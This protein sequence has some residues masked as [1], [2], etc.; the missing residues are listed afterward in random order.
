MDF[1]RPRF[2]NILLIKPIYHRWYKWDTG[3]FSACVYGRIP[4]ANIAIMH[5]Y[6]CLHFAAFQKICAKTANCQVCIITFEVKRYGFLLSNIQHTQRQGLKWTANSHRWGLLHCLSSGL[7]LFGFVSRA[8]ALFMC[9][10]LCANKTLHIQ[11][12]SPLPITFPGSLY[13]LEQATMFPHNCPTYDY[14]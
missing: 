11:L 3:Q 4:T 10:C 9:V 14:S 8:Y 12:S 2:E 7:S 6:L 1:C 13:V 5:C